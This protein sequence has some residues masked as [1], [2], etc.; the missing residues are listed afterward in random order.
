MGDAP[1]SGFAHFIG[2]VVG[3]WP[4][5]GKPLAYER[6]YGIIKQA[7]LEGL[8]WPGQRI[9]NERLKSLVGTSH[10][11]IRE[12]LR[13]LSAEGLVEAH[14]REGFTVP[15]V[16]E[17]IIRGHYEWLHMALL[18]SARKGTPPGADIL[19][20]IDFPEMQAM[21]I[22]DATARF[23]LAV[24]IA[25]GND[26]MEATVRRANDGLHLIRILKEDL[27]TDRRSELDQ[28][29]A[30]W[31]FGPLIEF[32]TALDAY[33]TRR[34]AILPEMVRLLHRRFPKN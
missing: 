4:M 22:A 7:I 24:A 26:G 3:V 27:L 2:A 33:F 6:V 29:I 25:G 21:S 17:P 8:F 19:A 32:E 20:E 28:L 13:R 5:V 9:D 30:L 23:F 10:I 16:T 31:R 15:Y 1:P 14:R 11:P 12:A 18:S 34:Y